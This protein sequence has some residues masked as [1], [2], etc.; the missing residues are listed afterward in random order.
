MLA[1][2]NLLPGLPLDGGRILRAAV[3]G[4]GARRPT[5]GTRVAGW[6]GRVLAVARRGVS[7]CLLDRGAGGVAGAALSIAL[8]AY[9]WVSA[10]PS[11]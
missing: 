5:T 8:G 11:R 1:V 9:L 3:W 10:T 7:A 2:F 4:C 6:S